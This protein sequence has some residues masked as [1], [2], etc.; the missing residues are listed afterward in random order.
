MARSIV[1]HSNIKKSALKRKNFLPTL[2]ITLLLWIL[3]SGLIYFVD[4]DTF[5]VVPLFFVALFVALLFTFSLIFA[6]SRRG[7]IASASLSLFSILM[8]LGVG[9]ILNLILIVAIAVS[10]ELYLAQK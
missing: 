10:I 8:Y 3:L 4:P 5:G 7:L 6:S 1:R 2:L 9:N